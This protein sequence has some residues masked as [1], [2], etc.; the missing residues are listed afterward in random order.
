MGLRRIDG[1]IYR[2]IGGVIDVQLDGWDRGI[3][4]SMKRQKDGGRAIL[5]PPSIMKFQISRSDY[6]NLLTKLVH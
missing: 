3:G 6:N 4:G 2:G 5:K 1:G